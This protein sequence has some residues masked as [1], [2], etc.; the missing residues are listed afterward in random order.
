MNEI[1][2]TIKHETGLH[3]RPAAL[4]VNTAKKF[5]SRITVSHGGKEAD[6]K[7][8]LSVMGLGV[9][10]EAAV[11]ICADGPDESDAIQQLKALVE[12]NFGE[13]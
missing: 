8:I 5:A 11:V 12:S 1:E 2:V 10:S 7:S 9:K 13:G 6:A 4:F 3:A